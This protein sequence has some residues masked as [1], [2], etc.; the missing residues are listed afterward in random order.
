MRQLSAELPWTQGRV[1]LFGRAIP[2]PRLSCWLGDPG[3]TYT[4][5]GQRR[6]PIPWTPGLAVL[7]ERVE[8]A[9]GLRFN[10]AL[11]NL[12]RSGADGVGWHADDEPE[13]G[14]EPAIASLSL[15]ATRRFSLRRRDDPRLRR[16]LSLDGGSLLVMAG[17]TQALWQHRVPKTRR[18]VGPRINLSFRQL[19]PRPPGRCG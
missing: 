3:C 18:P 5:S 13:L 7:K 16:E 9:T 10:S 2:E 1:Q 19:H 6:E 11:A 17:G 15:G 14:D 12:Y 8:A 4:Y